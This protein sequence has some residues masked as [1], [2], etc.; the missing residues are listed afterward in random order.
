MQNY[1]QEKRNIW[2]EIEY[3]K[4]QEVKEKAFMTDASDQQEG[5]FDYPREIDKKPK[6]I[7]GELP[8]QKYPLYLI[9]KS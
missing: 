9:T 5:G 4:K 1:E 2:K 8:Y 3:I 6:D 7:L